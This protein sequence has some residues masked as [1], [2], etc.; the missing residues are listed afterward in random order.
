MTSKTE[1]EFVTVETATYRIS[2][3]GRTAQEAAREAG[4]PLRTDHLKVSGGGRFLTRIPARAH[5]QGN[6]FVIKVLGMAGLSAITGPL[7]TRRACSARFD[8]IVL[9][10]HITE[11]LHHVF[12][13]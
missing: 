1:F 3:K 5:S 11:S 2:A 6:L 12:V 7:A 13:A 8:G 4:K 10:P 9:T